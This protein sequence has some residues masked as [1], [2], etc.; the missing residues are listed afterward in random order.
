MSF[1]TLLIPV[2]TSGDVRTLEQASSPD[3]VEE[4]SCDACPHPRADHDGIAAR[5]CSATSEGA[6]A[7][8]CACQP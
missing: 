8:G 5:F 2:T 6:I 1:S 4:M 7:R 3:D